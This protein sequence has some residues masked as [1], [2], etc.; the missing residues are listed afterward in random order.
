MTVTLTD[1]LWEL[2]E[3]VISSE[4]MELV[5][6]DYVRE[7]RGWVLRLYVDTEAGVTI[8]RC[9]QLSR[10]LGDLLD[11]K[12]IVPHRYILEVSSPGLNR[13]LKKEKDFITYRGQMITVKTSEPVEERKN[14]KG[15]LLDCR[16]GT[17]TVDADNRQVT[18]PLSLIT[19]AQLKYQFPDHT[20]KKQRKS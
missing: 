11:V 18:I 8:D 5:T 19:K 15:K 16:E 17:I 6:L 12:D 14:F 7:S 3:P 13:I 4:G 9:A 2:I 10:Q 20:R 1:A